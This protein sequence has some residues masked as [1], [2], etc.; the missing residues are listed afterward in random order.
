[1]DDSPE[2]RLYMT[3]ISPKR[4]EKEEIDNVLDQSSSKKIDTSL[5]TS[6]LNTSGAKAKKQVS[7]YPLKVANQT[8]EVKLV[9]A[10]LTNNK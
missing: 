8:V 7:I 4:V 10:Q 1:M 3:A 5:N 9:M 6:G 2:K